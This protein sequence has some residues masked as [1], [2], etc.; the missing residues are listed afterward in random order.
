MQ[1][2]ICH[3]G[4]SNFHWFHKGKGSDATCATNAYLD[5][6]KLCRDFFRWVLKCNSPLRCTRSK[7][8]GFL[9]GDLIDLDY[10]AINLMLYIMAMFVVMANEFFN[11]IT[12]CNYAES[13][14]CWKS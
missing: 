4:S 12:G 5:I 8:K 6:K 3:C 2:C 10:D 1:R 14:T 13:I 11:I 7:S 9:R